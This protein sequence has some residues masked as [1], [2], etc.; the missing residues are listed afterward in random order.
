MTWLTWDQGCTRLI[1]LGAMLTDFTAILPDGRGVSS[2]HKAPWLLPYLVAS[3]TLLLL[4]GTDGSFALENRAESYRVSLDWDAQT[5]PSL[6]LWI[7]NCGRN[8]A[9]WNGRH[10]ALGVEP[11]CSAFDLGPAISGSD[12]A[13]TRAG[14]QTARMLTPDQAFTTRYRMSFAPL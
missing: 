7:S 2:L 12:N 8:A 10:R 1:S 4:S 14:V 13:L 11:V 9:P 3:E 5:F 6:L